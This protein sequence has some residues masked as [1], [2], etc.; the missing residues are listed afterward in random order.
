MKQSKNSIL[1]LIIILVL[2]TFPGCSGTSPVAQPTLVATISMPTTAP[3]PPPPVLDTPT[4]PD[5]NAPIWVSNPEDQT[6]LRIDPQTNTIAAVVEI[7]GRPDVTSTGAGA[8]WAL[9]RRMSRVYRIDP[10]NNQVSAVIPLPSGDATALATG[11]GFVWVG[12]TGRIDLNAQTPG[13][14]EDITPPGFVIQID[15][16]TNQI[17]GQFPA[18]PINRLAVNGSTMWV[19]SSGVI[20]TPLQVFD[21]ISGQG[22]VVPFQNGPEWLP[23]D[24]MAVDAS[25]L[26]IYSSAYGR[27]FHATNTGQVRSAISL[28]ERQPV[29]Y[30]D[31][32]LADTGL[33][34]ITTWGTVLHIDPQ[35]NHIIGKIELNA[36]L[37]RL[38]ASP[39][40]IWVVSQQ[41]ATVF[42]ID[43]ATNAVTAQ[44]ATGSMQAAT[45]VPTPTTR[46]VQWKPC[47]DAPTS[48]LKVGDIAYVT[49]DPPLPNRVRKEPNREAE[50]LGLIVPGGGMDIIDGPSCS[51]GWVW[52]KVKNADLE[53][54]TPE[55][56]FE[57]YWL[58]PLYK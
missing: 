32:L 10:E 31:L 33:W 23:V 11:S 4:P 43:P 50:I 55:G 22:M 5:P 35:T 34:V 17:A 37:T 47:E 16:R 51:N 56:D 7:E 6:V 1:L 29:G 49:K 42:R 25:S 8:V 46:I 26:W 36:P 2:F 38:I 3:L 13:Q 53:G 48:R 28:E 39:N 27:I 57:T 20:D 12:I 21:L 45:I 14:E 9:D 18:Q 52:W 40:A 19:L 30:P 58:I 41:T 54:W 24:A 44:I 15:P